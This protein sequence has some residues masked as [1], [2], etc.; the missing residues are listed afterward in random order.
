MISSSILNA[1]HFNHLCD[2]FEDYVEVEEG[3]GFLIMTVIDFTDK[4]YYNHIFGATL[5]S[6]Y[7]VKI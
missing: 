1:E 4:F 7:K 3:H 6:G 5:P 2:C